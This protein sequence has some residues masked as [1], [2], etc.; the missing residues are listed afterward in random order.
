MTELYARELEPFEFQRKHTQAMTDT[1]EA[2][3]EGEIAVSTQARSQDYY[4]SVFVKSHFVK[5][6]LHV[7]ACSR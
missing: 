1:R 3:G 5:P 7:Q 4:T 6:Q 2:L